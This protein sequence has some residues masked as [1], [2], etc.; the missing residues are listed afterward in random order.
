MLSYYEVL[1]VLETATLAEIKAAYHSAALQH[2]PDK[3]GSDASW[4]HKVR[5]SWEVRYKFGDEPGVLRV[6]I[7]VFRCC[8]TLSSDVATTGNVQYIS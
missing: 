4:F 2:H 8:R 5:R 3:G 1:G 6:I 7:H